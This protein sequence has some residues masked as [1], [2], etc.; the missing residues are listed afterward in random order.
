M[1]K[2]WKHQVEAISYALSVRDAILHLGM[3]CGKSRIAVEVLLKLLEGNPGSRTLLGCPRAV[4]AAWAKQF[5]LWAPHVRIV[6]LDRG[7][8]KQKAAVVEAALADTTAVV[9]I[10]NYETLWR[11]DCLEKQRWDVL[12]WDEVHR[13]KSPSGAASKWAA[14]MGKK[15]PWAKRLGLSGTL[16]AHSLLDAFGVYRAMESP[17]CQTFGPFYTAFRNK[18]AV[19]HPLQ[20]GWVI[21]YR[22][23]AEFAEKIA[24]TTFHRRSEDVLDLPEIMFE[25]VVVDLGA[26]EARVYVDVEKNLCAAVEQGTMTVA[27]AMVAVLRLQQVCGGFLKLDDEI[28]VTQIEDT[29]S[30]RAALADLLED[31][32]ADEPVVV[33]CRFRSDIDS[34]L[35][36]C[37]QMGRSVSELSGRIDSLAAWQAGETAVL[38]AQIQ[39][40]GIGID[41]TR[42]RYGVFFSL[43]HS[44]AEYLQAVA[45]LHR[46]GQTRTT[47]FYHLVARLPHGASTV[48]ARVYQAL[49]E[50]KEVIDAVLDQYRP[51]HARQDA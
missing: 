32:A 24:A 18:F 15:N 27:N 48:D 45:R 38:V 34:C 2:L 12:I 29:P 51:R 36:A 30:K 37:E 40:G 42:A 17:E 35:K 41:L 21:G 7:T 47:H 31:M 4:M 1:T 39:S 49:S 6:V 13:L 20:R 14:R 16:L 8:A 26:K 46:P 28:A 10:G 5:K 25:D 9:I 44:L 11:M 33:F 3:G 19:Q 23:Q 22:N 50:R 43:G